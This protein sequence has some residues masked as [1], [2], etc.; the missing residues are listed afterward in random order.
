MSLFFKKKTETA[1]EGAEEET[2]ETQSPEEESREETEE[3]SS[4][5][6]S[7]EEKAPE[8][9]ENPEE[10]APGEEGSA[11]DIDETPQEEDEEVIE[12]ESLPEDFGEEEPVWDG[13]PEE[14]TSEAA[15]TAESTEEPE[16]KNKVFSAEIS[17][18]EEYV[19]TK[20]AE[21]AMYDEESKE[22]LEDMKLGEMEAAVEAILFAAGEA[23]EISNI[24]AVIGEDKGTAESLAESLIMKYNSE[25]RGINIIKINDS[26]QM[27][28]N[29]QFY[30]YIDRLFKQPKKKNLSTAV[31]E[32]LAIIAYKQPVTKNEI[33]EIRGVNSD[34][35]VNKLVEYDLVC[36]T[37]RKKAPGR[38]ILFG[39]TD[40]FLRVFG[41]SSTDAL[42][43]LKAPDVNAF[44]E[45]AREVSERLDK[46][47]NKDKQMNIFSGQA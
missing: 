18:A 15:E 4:E 26:Y 28:T 24:A 20:K 47:E 23:V 21:A 16:S 46:N 38:P 25:K 44:D 8:E 43:E 10:E 1:L 6:E 36:E 35:A 33:E 12:A 11:G 14:D 7:Q 17:P 13:E 45:A 29:R 31:L 27:C 22:G 30:N 40:E 42:P 5:A 9:A 41:Y 37:G 39:T 19:V 2:I 32:V 34:R 3:E